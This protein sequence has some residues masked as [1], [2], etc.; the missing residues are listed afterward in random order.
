MF[1]LKKS[2]VLR[3]FI[4]AFLSLILLIPAAMIQE[5]ISEREQRRNAA[6]L[7]VSDKWG[8]E[9]TLAGLVLSVPHKVALREQQTDDK[10]KVTVKTVG[11]KIEYVHLLPEVL[12]IKA[13]LTPEIRH[14]GIYDI[15]LYNAAVQFSGKFSLAELRDLAIDQPENLQWENATVSL[16]ISD[17]KGIREVIP[18][19]W[20]GR[21]LIAN[22]G[23][24]TRDV[25]GNVAVKQTT[26]N[27]RPISS[28]ADDYDRETVAQGALASGV[29]A[30]L[31]EPT[32]KDS[33][34]STYTF[35][36][37]LNLN[38]SETFRVVPIGKQTTVTLSSSWTNPS[39]IGAYLP[40]KP[41]NAEPQ[42]FSAT[43]KVL[44]LNRDYPQAW[45]GNA[46]RIYNSAFGVKLLMPI[47]EYQKNMRTAKYAIMFIGLTFLAFF[48]TELL[49][50]TA[51]HPI[52]YLLIGLALV[53]FYILLLSLSEQF[54]FN[55]AYILSSVGVIGLI[56]FYAQ[57]VLRKTAPTVFITG[58]LVIL[59]GFLFTILQLQDYALLLG[60]LL[61]F[62]A[63][64]LVMALTRNIDWFN[65]AQVLEEKAEVK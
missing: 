11:E 59:Y 4:I 14:R 46:H 47:D 19:T 62:I 38:G 20:N 48:M 41:L 65:A 53:I 12:D 40:E 57:S 22:P 51:I 3:L 26:F 8:S 10:G 33:T 58:I 9:Q 30:K 18:I 15:A 31:N 39:A 42:G 63:L 55:T 21:E 35:S 60:S 6:V 44:H 50:K 43:W 54:G 52:Q 1:S 27:T 32:L 2:I 28:F 61:L 5:L 23:L 17:L 16:G 7:E 49:N 37:A 45:I 64:A 34:V 25:V 29:T 56:A 24:P 13:H 36:A